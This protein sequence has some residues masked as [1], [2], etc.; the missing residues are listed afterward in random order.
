MIKVGKIAEP[1]QGELYPKLT[2][3]T[4]KCPP[5]DVGGFSGYEN[6][7]EAIADP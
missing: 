4:G 2:D 5:E 7:L 6:F 3:V 1:A